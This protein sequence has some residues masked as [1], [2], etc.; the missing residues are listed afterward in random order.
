MDEVLTPQVTDVTYDQGL[1]WYWDQRD[2]A[3]ACGHSGGDTGVATEMFFRVDDETAVV[4]LANGDWDDA[5]TL[6]DIEERLFQEAE[7]F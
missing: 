7:G 1:I 5:E 3:R 6:V 4:A 2:G